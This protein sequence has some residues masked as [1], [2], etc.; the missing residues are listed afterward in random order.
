VRY[1]RPLVRQTVQ[2]KN[3]ISG[4][5]METAT[6]PQQTAAAQSGLFPRASGKQPRGE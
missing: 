3:R 4:L 2:M 6:E 5:V 1:R